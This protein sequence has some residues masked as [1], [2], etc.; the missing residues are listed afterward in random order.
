VGYSEWAPWDVFQIATDSSGALYLS[1]G[2]TPT[3]LTCVTKLSADG[4]TILWQ[5]SLG[6]IPTAMAVD[7]NGGV[8][9]IPFPQ[10]GDTSVYVVKLGVGGTGIAWKTPVGFSLAPETLQAFL[11][12][13]SSGRAYVAG[14]SGDNV[15]DVVRLNADGSGV[16]YSAQ[17]AGTPTGIAANASGEAFVIG[18]T[19]APQVGFLAKLGPDGSAGFYSDVAQ[20]AGSLALDSNGNAVV[21]AY[22]ANGSSA[23]Q[24]FDPTGALTLS[25]NV[26]GATGGLALDE[27]GNA[28]VIGGA[29]G[30]YPVKNTLATCGSVFLSVYAPDGSLLQGTSVP[31]SAAITTGPNS[32][33][34][35]TAAADTTFVPTQTG[36]FPSGSS[37]NFLLQLSPNANAQTFPLACLGNSATYGI[38]PIAPGGFVTLFGSGLGPQQGVLTQATPQSPYPTQTANVQVT[39]DGKPAPLLWV[40]DHRSMC[41]RHGR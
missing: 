3:S 2:C 23:L 25:T 5:N 20:G 38:G 27:A 29:S 13:D 11:A 14:L 9:V 30:L 39:F 21:L 17:M 19:A 26:P 22:L 24:R 7:P 33:V 10:P 18:N 6:F 37:T 8:Y 15:A 36:P 4:K 31:G 16:D 41:W 35:L 34:F 32:T 28:Y 1:A 12:A 40:Q